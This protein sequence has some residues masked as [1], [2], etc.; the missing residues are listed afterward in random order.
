MGVAD[1]LGSVVHRE[2]E[3]RVSVDVV[4]VRP[5]GSVGVHRVRFVRAKRAAHAG[6]DVLAQVVG[7]LRRPRRSLFEPISFAGERC[8]CGF[9]VG[10]RSWGCRLM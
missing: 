5:V 3:I 7:H 6:G 9:G 1:E 4:D 8:G 2:V 10:P